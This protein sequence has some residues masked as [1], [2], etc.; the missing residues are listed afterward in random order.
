MR[1]STES[2]PDADRVALAAYVSRPEQ[3]A[4]MTIIEIEGFF[5]ALA[6][7]PR[8]RAPVEWL[9]HVLGGALPEFESEAETDRAMAALFSVYNTVTA[10]VR[11]RGG[12]LPASLDFRDDLEAN[13]EPD[14]PVSQWARGFMRGHLWLEEDWRTFGEEVLEEIALS[15]WGLGLWGKRS[16]LESVLEEEEGDASLD[17]TLARARRAFPDCAAL[18]AQSGLAL[19]E[20]ARELERQRPAVRADRPGR[21]A[22]CPCDSGQKYK[23]CCG[24]IRLV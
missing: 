2:I 9:P 6:A 3:E 13:L 20:L 1:E 22:P 16:T 10:D 24:R 8:L 14:A 12:A 7:A 17:D 19:E 15:V 5:F 4:W 21:N 23:K 11:E 18:Y